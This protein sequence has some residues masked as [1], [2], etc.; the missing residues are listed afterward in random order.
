VDEAAE[1]TQMAG[2]GET[3][4]DEVELRLEVDAEDAEHARGEVAAIGEVATEDADDPPVAFSGVVQVIRVGANRRGQ[5]GATSAPAIAQAAIDGTYRRKAQETYAWYSDDLVIDQDA[6][7]SV[8]DRVVPLAD[9]TTQ[10][11][12]WVAR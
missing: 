5:R 7:V 1:G 10:R 12:R 9:P 11:R 8:G 4:M 3:T 6:A 2:I